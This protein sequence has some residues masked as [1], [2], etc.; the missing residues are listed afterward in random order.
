M[1]F[2][3]SCLA[4]A[5]P[6]LAHH[7]MG[8]NTP[9]NFAEGLLSGLGHPIIGIDHLVFAIAVGL[10]AVLSNRWG[11]IIPLGFIVATV[12][13]TAIHLQGIDLPIVEVVIAT[14]VLMVGMILARKDPTKLGWLV[15]IS[16]IAGIFHGY[17]YGESIIGA[18]TAALSA[19]LLGFAI[20]QFAISFAAYLLGSKILQ[21]AQTNLPQN[22]GL[23]FAGFTI[24]GIGLAFLSSTILG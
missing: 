16:A 2:S 21:P 23:R 14:S 6:V 24:A 4:Y 10:L 8:G 19:Y 17:A 1:V 13:G 11:M 3:I 9:R 7:P 18:E 5:H 15:M 22:L 12:L 20:I